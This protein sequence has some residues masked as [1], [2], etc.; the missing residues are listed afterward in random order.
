MSAANVLSV[1]APANANPPTTYQLKD[2][3]CKVIYYVHGLPAVS[4]SA[5]AWFLYDAFI[6]D[7]F[8]A[9][10]HV[11]VGKYIF[12]FPMS[13]PVNPVSFVRQHSCRKQFNVKTYQLNQNECRICVKCVCTC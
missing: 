3:L 8:F 4:W 7:I 13:I 6:S 5:S 2:M 9:I 1:S 12:S 10:S 11:L